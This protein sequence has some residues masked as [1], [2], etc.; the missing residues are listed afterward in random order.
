[1]E[2]EYASK[3]LANASLSLSEASR[4]FGVPIGRKYIQR[5]AVLRAVEKFQQ[6][7]GL[8]ALK[9]HPLKGDREGQYAITLTGNCR[10]IVE[11][12]A[13]DKIRVVNIEDYHND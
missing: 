11:Q 1:M 12:I 2:I 6:L 4:F 5:I 3:R 13:E 8:Q 9:L 7:F 10:L